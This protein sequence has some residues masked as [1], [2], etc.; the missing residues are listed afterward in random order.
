M[1]A[2]CITVV[3]LEDSFAGFS[4][5]GF[6]ISLSLQL[7][8]NGLKLSEAL[9]TAKFT[10][11]GFFVSF[12]WPRASSLQHGAEKGRKTGRTRPERYQ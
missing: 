8:Q 7:Q 4:A 1:A 6:P 3:V 11:S 12:F 10:D 9:W 5:V 2:K